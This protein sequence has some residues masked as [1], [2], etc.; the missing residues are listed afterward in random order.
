MTHKYRLLEKARGKIVS[1][2]MVAIIAIVKSVSKCMIM[3]LHALILTSAQKKFITAI[4]AP[5][6]LTLPVVFIANVLLGLKVMEWF[7]TMLMSVDRYFMTAM[8]S[9]KFAQIQLAHTIVV[10]L[11]DSLVNPALML[12]SVTVTFTTVTKMRAYVTIL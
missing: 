6:V 3:I 4:L 8:I 10:V 12:T 2:Q 5:H 7:V 11:L 1:I 9:G